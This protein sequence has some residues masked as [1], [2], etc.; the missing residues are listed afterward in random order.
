MR[1]GDAYIG[2][3]CVGDNFLVLTFNVVWQGGNLII[4]NFVVALMEL[5]RRD[6]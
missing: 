4:V 3:V 5:I 1:R 6:W 2:S